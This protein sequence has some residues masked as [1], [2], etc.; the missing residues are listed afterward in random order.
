MFQR[1]ILK[2]EFVPLK[3]YFYNTDSGTK[4]GYCC[5]FPSLT[6]T[7]SLPQCNTCPSASSPRPQFLLSLVRPSLL[8]G[9]SAHRNPLK[10]PAAPKPLLPA[11]K[12]HLKLLPPKL[13]KSLSLSTFTSC[14]KAAGCL[15]IWSV[16]ME[17][18][19]QICPTVELSTLSEEG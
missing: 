5:P 14:W 8:K 4:C 13:F 11:S 16:N 12:M 15:K 6:S 18:L 10:V 1:Y 3:R 9:C 19:F 7:L 2:C 17:V